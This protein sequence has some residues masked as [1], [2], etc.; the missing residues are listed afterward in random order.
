MWLINTDTLRLEHVLSPDGHPYAILSHTWEDDEVTFQDMADPDTA[1]CQSKKGFSKIK[2]TCLRASLR[3]LRYAWVDTCC[4][5]KESSAELTEAINSMF[6]WYKKADICFAYLSDFPA[7]KP[8]FPDPL[9]G[10]CRWW[11]RGWTLQELLAPTNLYFFD[12]EWN[13]HGG[14]R[15]R[16]LEIF[17]ITGID[18]AVLENSALM[19]SMPVARKMSWVARRQTTREEDM[20]YCLLGIFDVNM[21]LIYGEGRKAFMRLQEKILDKTNDMTLF[22]WT[23][24]DQSE[25]GYTGMA[26]ERWWGYRGVLARS[27]VEFK[28]C[29]EVTRDN[30]I[31]LNREF[32]LT[33][34][35]LRIRTYLARGPADD[36]ILYV[37]SCQRL[38]GSGKP[39]TQR[40]GIHLDKTPTGFCRRLPGRLYF[41]HYHSANPL[42]RRSATPS[43]IYIRKELTAQEAQ[44]T[45]A[46]LGAIK[47]TF[48]LPAHL[49]LAGVT[50]KPSTIWD[51]HRCA[52]LA[53]T[54]LSYLAV[55]HVRLASTTAKS[56]NNNNK[57]ASF[58]LVCKIASRM[59]EVGRHAVVWALLVCASGTDKQQ[60][61]APWKHLLALL[62][63]YMRS[64]GAGASERSDAMPVSPEL[65]EL[66][67][68]LAV[69][70][71]TPQ[72]AH[73][74]TRRG[75][76]TGLSLEVGAR[77]EV[78]V[79]FPTAPW[80]HRRPGHEGRSWSGTAA[81]GGGGG[82][83][84]AAAVKLTRKLTRSSLGSE[85]SQSSAWT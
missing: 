61:S 19:N 42:T 73:L 51:P 12:C 77:D 16:S 11:T 10:A 50:V 22:A 54:G 6:A 47:L 85:E 79:L 60:L 82:A 58:L 3:G 44:R 30:Y 38:D 15:I 39:G 34:A 2:H 81:Q 70:A 67:T 76:R 4:I 62:Q 23:A 68:Q 72:W 75:V 18:M 14:K 1:L 36:Y 74:E 84:V 27:P 33:N 13:N 26:D 40:I 20:A 17:E 56:N 64:S 9:L 49:Q 80:Y 7:H 45:E 32:S 69:S 35:G 63:E 29:N 71:R 65:E 28:H 83:L 57:P 66:C 46:R 41:S 8:E 48:D 43:T 53:Q 25:P 5:N 55:C 52:F 59:H 24:Q 37:G 31:D 78:R 21:S